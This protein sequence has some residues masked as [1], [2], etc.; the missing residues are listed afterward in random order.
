[1]K[2]PLVEEDKAA[3]D[4]SMSVLLLLIYAARMEYQSF[5]DVKYP[6]PILNQHSKRILESLN[7]IQTHLKVNRKINISIENLDTVEEYAASLL[8]IANKLIDLP[9]E[10][11]KKATI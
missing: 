7:E 1:M 2:R 11:A 5:I 4:K 10:E 6:M 8:M 3:V 9:L